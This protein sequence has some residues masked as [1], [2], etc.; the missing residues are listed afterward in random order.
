MIGQK[1]FPRRKF[2]R[3][4]AGAAALPVVTRFAFAQN[5]PSRP[6]RI[7]VGTSAG[8][9]ID[10]AA[11]LIAQALSE[12]LG[13]QFYVENKVG[14]GT[15]VGAEMV[16]RAPPDGYMLFLISAANAINATLYT[17]LNFNF[18]RDMAP[19]AGIARVPQVMEVHPSVSAKTVPEFIAYAKANPGKLNMASAGIGSVQQVGGE[20]FKMMTGVDMVHVA[21][22][23]A[24]P[25]MVDLLGGQMQ[26]MF[27][28]MPSSIEHIRAGKLRALGVTTASRSDA[29]PKLPTVSQF[30]PGYESSQWYGLGATRAT[31]AEIV[32]KV[33]KAV[34]EAL[35]D[36]KFGTRLAEIGGTP[37]AGSPAD[38]GKLIAEDTDK[39]AKVV[40]FSGAKVE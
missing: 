12:R 13:Q 35:V 3:L 34:N 22:K 17:K 33:N 15:N 11:R 18:I 10:I 36:P 8:G 26:V 40:R 32:D 4:A 2:L 31:P 37:L 9:G 28:T 14:A 39:W 5:Y 38:F 1:K 6:V 27:D 29:L 25:A 7:V 24:G 21:Y 20:L 23:G 16:V 30:V 19:V